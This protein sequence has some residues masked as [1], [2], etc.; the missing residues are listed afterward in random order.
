MPVSK[1]DRMP[2]PPVR[3]LFGVFFAR[4]FESETTVG[5][6]DLRQSLL[7]LIGCLA[8]PGVFW[9]FWQSFRWQLIAMMH[10]EEALRLAVLFDKTLYLSFTA[11]AIG[12][13]ACV[14]WP[15]LVIDRRDALIL[16]VWPVCLRSIVLGKLAALAAYIGIIAGGMHAGSALMFGTLL[17]AGSPIGTVRATLGHFVSAVAISLFV[18]G[19]IAALAT[20]TLAIAGPRRFQRLSGALQIACVAIVTTGLVLLPAISGSTVRTIRGDAAQTEWI[21]DTPPLGHLGLYE[22]IGGRWR[23]IMADLAWT[24]LWTLGAVIVVLLAA[25]PIACR[26][27]LAATSGRAV[28]ASRPWSRTLGTAV[29]RWLARVPSTRATLQFIVATIGRIQ[30]HRLMLAIAMGIAL[31]ICVPILLAALSPVS[32]REPGA[33]TVPL[34]AIGP[35]LMFFAAAGL[36]VAMAMPAELPARWLFASAPMPAGAGRTAARRLMWLAAV[37]PGAV[38]T[39]VIATALWHVGWALVAAAAV[40][41]A[42]A[43]LTEIHLWGFVGVPCAR[44]LAPGSAKMQSRWPLYMT[45]LYLISVL[46]PT[47]IAGAHDGRPIAWLLVLIVPLA[48]A[49]RLGSERAAA[50][51]AVSELDED[52]LLLLDLSVPTPQK[53][54]SNARGT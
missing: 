14:A 4:F 2:V 19:G 40:A 11:I 20:V 27:V 43:L 39:A 44:P 21:L 15:S 54:T 28:A 51:N 12:L 17:G 13:V 29:V 32:T 3:A 50:V 45:G 26:R 53:V 41:A 34:L 9:G 16:G 8:A 5:P 22:A 52:S 46:L 33:M 6:S 30:S 24:A 36:R 38:L 25:Y 49:A 10:G 48:I 42:G 47:F 35:T 7:W 1:Q 37:A 18:F 23:P 31:T